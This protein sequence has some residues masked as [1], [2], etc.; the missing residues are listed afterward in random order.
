LQRNYAVNYLLVDQLVTVLVRGW[1][2]AT[3]QWQYIV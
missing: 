3:C 2:K 1:R